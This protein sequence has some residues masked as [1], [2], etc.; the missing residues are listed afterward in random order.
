MNLKK[1]WETQAKFHSQLTP[2]LKEEIRDTVIFYQR[3]LKSQKGLISFCEFESK[4]IEINK[5]GKI[6]KRRSG[7]ESYPGLHP[8][9]RNL[10]SGRIYQM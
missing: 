7:K 10:K 6:I 1:I 8:Y 5:D 9:F 4:E 3:K 2:Q